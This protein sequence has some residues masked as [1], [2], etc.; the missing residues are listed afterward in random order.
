MI[1]IEIKRSKLKEFYKF[2]Q[3]Q[4]NER[5]KKRFNQDLLESKYMVEKLFN[6]VD[7]YS[8]YEVLKQYKKMEKELEG[9]KL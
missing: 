1:D 3:N 9:N 7:N 8:S 4:V 2:L 5:L 6:E